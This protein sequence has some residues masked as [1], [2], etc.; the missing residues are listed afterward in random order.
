[1]FLSYAGCFVPVILGGGGEYRTSAHPTTHLLRGCLDV[2]DRGLGYCVK[3]SAMEDGIT[4]CC[5][6]VFVFHVTGGASGLQLLHLN[7]THLMI[8]LINPSCLYLA[9]ESL[10]DCQAVDLVG[11]LVSMYILSLYSN[12]SGSNPP[13][14]SIAPPSWFLH[15]PGWPPASTSLCSFPIEKTFVLFQPSSVSAFGLPQPHAITSLTKSY[16]LITAK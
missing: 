14:Q 16:K 10:P 7:Q 3:V 5:W 2:G 9:S 15:Q 6:S 1:M 11:F 13:V 12:I 8:I 4:L